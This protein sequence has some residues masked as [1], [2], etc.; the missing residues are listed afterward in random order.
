MSPPVVRCFYCIM[1]LLLGFSHF[2]LYY[3]YSNTNTSIQEIINEKEREKAK[4]I[5]DLNDEY[6]VEIQ[7]LNERYLKQLDEVNLKHFK[8]I[9]ELKESNNNK[10]QELN[11]EMVSLKIEL[12]TLRSR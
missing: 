5:K 3:L 2:D 1:F 7:D 12:D 6:K 10:I 8:I 9:D 11:N 4:E